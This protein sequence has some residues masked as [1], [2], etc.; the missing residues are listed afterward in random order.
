[1]VRRALITGGSGDIGGECARQLARA[2]LHVYV[3][4]NTQLAKAE[5]IA[6]AI[7]AAGGAA[8]AVAF[9]LTDGAATQAAI[10]ELVAR[11]PLQVV[12]HCAGIH[13]DGPMA[14]LSDEH[15]HKVI[16][17]S[18]HGFFNVTKPLLLPMLRTRWGRIVALSSI[19]GQLGNRGQTN[20]AAAK[21]GLHG[22]VLSLAKEVASRGVTANIVSPGLVAGTMTDDV[23]DDTA[24]KQ[25]V[26][27]GRMGRAEEVAAVV[28]FLVSDAASYVTGQIIGVN[29][30]MA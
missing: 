14:G 20:Y 29:G 21:A 4:A 28:A 18:L 9:D 7:R 24:V 30:G 1:M 17:V 3:H 22:A 12:V 5:A 10:H 11:E 6:E 25:L 15:W 19:A 27:M 26:P 16:D 23:F 2:G 13:H 8:E